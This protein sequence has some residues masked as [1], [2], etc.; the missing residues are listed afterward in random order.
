[1]IVAA[2]MALMAGCTPS[3]PPPKLD[4]ANWQPKSIAG[5]IEVKPLPPSHTILADYRKWIETDSTVKARVYEMILAGATNQRDFKSEVERA[6]TPAVHSVTTRVSF[7]YH[8]PTN[9]QFRI[10]WFRLGRHRGDFLK[11]NEKPKKAWVIPNNL[12]D[13]EGVPELVIQAFEGLEATGV[14]IAKPGNK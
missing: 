11:L 10:L 8:D 7:T 12:V 3:Q 2:V 14:L 5:P 13:H 1:M 9:G 6:D 4:A